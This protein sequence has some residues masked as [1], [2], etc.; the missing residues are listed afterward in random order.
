MRTSIL[1]AARR[2]GGVAML[3]LLC[4][5]CT[6]PPAIPVSSPKSSARSPAPLCPKCDGVDSVLRAVTAAQ[7]EPPREPKVIAAYPPDRQWEDVRPLTDSVITCDL[8]IEA[9]VVDGEGGIT[10]AA[11]RPRAP[12][13]LTFLDLDTDGPLIK[14]NVP[15]LGQLRK[16]SDDGDVLVLVEAASGNMFVYSISRSK[17]RIVFAKAYFVGGVSPFGL[18]T[19]GRCY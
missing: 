10:A 19:M 17:R 12:M 8:R 3:A 4:A 1:G 13:I 15:G 16:V 9:S 7:A 11:S 2:V 18:A 5:A 6:P 14:G